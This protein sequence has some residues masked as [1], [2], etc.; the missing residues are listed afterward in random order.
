MQPTTASK[1]NRLHIVR[2]L[3]SRHTPTATKAGQSLTIEYMKTIEKLS[4]LERVKNRQILIIENADAQN[5]FIDCD[6]IAYNVR[7]LRDSETKEDIENYATDLVNAVGYRGGKTLR[8]Q[9]L[10]QEIK[11]IELN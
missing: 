1:P 11:D 5:N 9:S 7:K 2:G 3:Q 6:V 10:L 4:P 8:L